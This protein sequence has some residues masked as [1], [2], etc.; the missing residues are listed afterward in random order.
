MSWIATGAAALSV[1]GGISK[2][3]ADEKSR[4][5]QAA[6]E[7]LSGEMQTQDIVQSGMQAGRGMKIGAEESKLARGRSRAQEST[8]GEEGARA[9]SLARSMRDTMAPVGRRTAQFASVLGA[10]GAAP[11]GM[12][13]AG[14]AGNVFADAMRTRAGTAGGFNRALAGTYGS[15]TAAEDQAISEGAGVADTMRTAQRGAASREAIDTDVQGA[16]RR[17]DFER[18][19]LPVEQA[20]YK[21]AQSDIYAPYVK[22]HFVR[23]SSLGKYAGMLGDVLG[24]FA[25]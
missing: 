3:K 9:A 7:S 16:L 20:E 19:K 23:E 17:V 13:R 15:L 1:I 11:G 12:F 21:K 4:R 6:Q 18:Y 10:P 22:P 8:R 2:S 24:G 5:I 14:T 25:R